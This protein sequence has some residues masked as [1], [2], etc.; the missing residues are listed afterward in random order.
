MAIKGVEVILD[1]GRM[2][3]FCRNL[4]TTP[5]NIVKVQVEESLKAVVTD[6]RKI[7]YLA[8]AQRLGPTSSNSL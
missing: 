4:G 6:A 7:A 8:W 2:I 3:V 5:H 1:A